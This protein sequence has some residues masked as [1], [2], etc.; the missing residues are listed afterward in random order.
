[1]SGGMVALGD[2]GGSDE[3]ESGYEMRLHDRGFVYRIE[4]SAGQQPANPYDLPSTSDAEHFGYGLTKGA[5]RAAAPD[6][7][8]P[9][10]AALSKDRRAAW[11][12]ALLGT[13]PHRTQ[14]TERGMGT[15]F[16][17]P[18]GCVARADAAVYGPSWRK[19]SFDLESLDARVVHPVLTSPSFLAGQHRWAACMQRAHITAAT[20]PAARAPA[21]AL[22]TSYLNGKASARHGGTHQTTR[23]ARRHRLP[24]TCGPSRH[25]DPRAAHRGESAAGRLAA[26][27]LGGHRHAHPSARRRLHCVRRSLS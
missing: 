25:R 1:M 15:F 10:L 13:A 5:A 19:D 26:N 8:A 24:A 21:E 7:D 22:L 18:N 2:D 6:P 20:L 9:V 27:G 14:I 11:T 12:A 17:D 16:Y 23:R 4:P 3:P